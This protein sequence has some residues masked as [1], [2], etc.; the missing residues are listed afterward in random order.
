MSWS[1]IPKWFTTYPR[2]W[3]PTKT[4]AAS[5]FV[6]WGKFIA[7][8]RW[9]YWC[10]GLPPRS[11]RLESYTEEICILL[12]LEAGSWQGWFLPRLL[13]WACRWS[14]GRLPLM[15]SCGSPCVLI[16]YRDTGQTRLMPTLKA[17]LNLNYLFKDCL[18]IQS[19][20]EALG[21]R[22]LLTKII[23]K[24]SIIR[25]H[26]CSIWAKLRP[27]AERH[28]FRKRLSCVLPDGTQ[29]RLM[30]AGTAKLRTLLVKN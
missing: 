19:H 9:A 3:S 18:Q 30:E 27:I 15:F 13:S 11:H 6:L 4:L 2:A 22:T 7:L 14:P 24:L 17:S 12:I 1:C 28:R 23:N 20:F 16:S 26:N 29:R 10:Y 8:N 25:I 21:V 5:H